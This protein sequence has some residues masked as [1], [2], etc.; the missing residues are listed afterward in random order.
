MYNRVKMYNRVI[1]RFIVSNLDESELKSGKT[2]AK[3][4]E[5][6]KEVF[7]AGIQLKIHFTY[8]R[9]NKKAIYVHGVCNYPY[10]VSM[11]E[12]D[13]NE[14]NAVYTGIDIM[15]MINDA[16]TSNIVAVLDM[17]IMNDINCSAKI[18]E[19]L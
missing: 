18:D 11:E 14:E 19:L 1:Y 2:F 5:L 9:M 6:V 15:D 10:E 16:E 8:S 3:F 13:Y 7:F 4:L 17:V 12:E